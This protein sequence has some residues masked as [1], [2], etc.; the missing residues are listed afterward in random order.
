MSLD[1]LN[2]IL[3]SIRVENET[4]LVMALLFVSLTLLSLWRLGAGFAPG[5]R[6]IAAYAAVAGAV[7]YAV[8]SG[9]PIHV[10]PGA[11]G[12]GEAMTA[13]TL[14]GLDLAAS[15]AQAAATSGARLLV[16]TASPLLLPL[17]DAAQREAHAAAGYPQDYKPDQTR[18][19]SDNRNAYAL[20]V[21]TLA[22]RERVVLNVLAGD[23]ADEYLLAAEPAAMAGTELIAGTGNPRTLPFVVATADHALLG[24]ELFAAG[25]Y[26]SRKSGSVASLLA[27]DQMRLLLVC[28]IL[29]GVALESL[30]AG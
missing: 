23:L 10:S 14:A 22:R 9:H 29:V 25:A 4:A 20:G 26:L 24:E 2:A 17:I 11:G 13:Q 15:L 1:S 16:T 30:G 27:Q 21:G 7:E 3:A 19:L 6:P 28:L 18:F 8:E 5:L 12:V